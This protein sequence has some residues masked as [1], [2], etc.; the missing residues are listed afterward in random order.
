MRSTA[1]LADARRESPPRLRAAHSRARAAALR[2]ALAAVLLASS[3]PAATRSQARRDDPQPPV[4]QKQQPRKPDA[5]A[6]EILPEDP[7]DVLT[8]DTNLVLV[9][10]TVTDAEGRPVRDLRPEDF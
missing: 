1:S 8:V 3:L 7:D 10:V 4:Q 6:A 5:G 2:S 9:D